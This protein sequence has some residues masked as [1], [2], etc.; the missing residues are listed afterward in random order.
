VNSDLAFHLKADPDPSCHSNA[1]PDP[2]FHSHA[3]PDPA[4]NNNADPQPSFINLYL[5]LYFIAERQM[6]V[7]EKEEIGS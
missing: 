7:T 2:S 6:F 4:S 1:D 3:G 5:H